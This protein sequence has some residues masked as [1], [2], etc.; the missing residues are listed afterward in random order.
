MVLSELLVI[1]LLPKAPRI[2]QS[3]G[4]A[5]VQGESPEDYAGHLEYSIPSSWSSPAHVLSLH[6]LTCGGER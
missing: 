6:V 5:A 1:L 3:H 2:I 4:L